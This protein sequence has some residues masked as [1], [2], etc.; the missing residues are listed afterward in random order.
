MLGVKN[1]LLLKK[2]MALSEFLI[3]NFPQAMQAD[4]QVMADI[5]VG[6]TLWSFWLAAL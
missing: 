4:M 2:I 1:E 6:F 5:L 3:S